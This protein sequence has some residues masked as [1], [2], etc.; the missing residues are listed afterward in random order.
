MPLEGKNALI[1]LDGST[2]SD[3]TATTWTLKPQPTVTP[4]RGRQRAALGVPHRVVRPTVLPA[5][6]RRAP[7]T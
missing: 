3:S 7:R 6:D 5:V 4:D 1:N 2:L